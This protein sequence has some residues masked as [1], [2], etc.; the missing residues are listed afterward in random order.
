M[1]QEPAFA[2]SPGFSPEVVVRRSVSSEE[3]APQEWDGFGLEDQESLL[4]EVPSAGDG[5]WPGFMGL[6]FLSNENA[7]RILNAEPPLVRYALR[8]DL[9]QGV[10][11][12][13]WASPYGIFSSDEI[14]VASDD[15][16]R[17]FVVF[18][19]EKSD[20]TYAA[21]SDL[22]HFDPDSVS[23]ATSF[24]KAPRVIRT[25]AEYAPM[26][27][28]QWSVN[29]DEDVITVKGFEESFEELYENLD[30]KDKAP[31]C[32][33]KLAAESEEGTSFRGF[34]EKCFLPFLKKALTG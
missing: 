12:Y 3:V 8:H 13:Q 11:W 24:R 32:D 20:A 28:D 34:V 5:L 26:V 25:L 15:K 31:K 27:P 9:M 16:N 30:F 4:D 23:R 19:G 18:F 10:S 29:V 6:T 33:W 17:C 22:P 14:F 2:Q 1:I 21:E 7:D